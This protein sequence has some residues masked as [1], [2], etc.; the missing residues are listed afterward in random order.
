MPGMQSSIMKEL[1]VTEKFG[2]SW[3]GVTLSF[4]PRFQRPKQRVKVLD[5]VSGFALSGELHCL[6]GGSGSGKTSLLHALSGRIASKKFCL[7]GSVAL[8]G[9]SVC[10]AKKTRIATIYQDDLL[11]A[12]LTVRETLDMSALFYMSVSCQAA[13]DA[14]V[15]MVMREMTLINVTNCIV[16]SEVKRGLSGGERRRVSIARELISVPKILLCDEITSGLDSWNALSV[17]RT[18]KALAAAGRVV[19]VA[20]HQPRSDIYNC[21]DR[22]SLLG[23]GRMIY[24]GERSK[25]GNYFGS[26]G[27]VCPAGFNEADFLI[28]TLHINLTNIDTETASRERLVQLSNHLESTMRDQDDIENSHLLF[29]QGNGFSESD[30]GDGESKDDPNARQRTGRGGNGGG[31]ACTDRES[32][33]SSMVDE[34]ELGDKINECGAMFWQKVLRWVQLTFAVFKRAMLKNIR[35][36]KDFMVTMIICIFLATILS[37]LY[38]ETGQNTAQQLQNR[39]GLLFFITINQ[40]F[41][42]CLEAAR[43]FH[44]EKQIVNNEISTGAY[45]TSAYFV[46]RFCATLPYQLMLATVSSSIIYF[47]VGFVLDAGKFFIFLGLVSFT[48]VA[49]QSFGLLMSAITPNE[50][51]AASAVTPFIIIFVLTGG[52]Y[53]SSNSFPPGAEWLI[54]TSYVYYP[55]SALVVNELSGQTFDCYSTIETPC[56]QTGE[57]VLFFLGLGNFTILEG[58]VGLLLLTVL[59]LGMAYSA[60]ICLQVKYLAMAPPPNSTERNQI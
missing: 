27:F 57:Q 59:F 15:D 50:Q 12:H 60:L 22:L 6:L 38:Y 18:L 43:A 51:L 47:S 52:F 41:G 16:G 40:S 20:I 9:S 55:F 36:W 26:L 35:M 7:T 14:R 23:E 11:Y 2:I 28:D 53:L 56:L 54:Y 25:T 8:H 37:L 5:E 45:P 24:H 32:I 31:G 42:P 19:M 34:S 1:E 10:Q 39:I 13:R 44:G 33:A 48:A 4:L 17:I 58:F 46:G 3:S 49:G 30:E 21:F 29:G